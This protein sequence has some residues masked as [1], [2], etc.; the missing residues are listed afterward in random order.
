[1]LDLTNLKSEVVKG[2]LSGIEKEG[3]SFG[4]SNITFPCPEM[5]LLGLLDF[6]EGVPIAYFKSREGL[7]EIIG[8]GSTAKFGE[9][10]KNEVEKIINSNSDLKFF[11]SLRFNPDGEASSEWKAL[12][13]YAFFLP[14]VCWVKQE[15]N[16]YLEVNFPNSLRNMPHERA[17][18]IMAL[19]NHIDLTRS[20]SS[21]REPI[22]FKEHTDVPSK[23]MWNSSINECLEILEST[24]VDKVVL[25][26]KRILN[27]STFNPVNY[28]QKLSEKSENS[29]L[30][31]IKLNDGQAFFS[32]SPERLFKKSNDLL[33]I[34]S[35]AGT[36]TRGFTPQEDQILERELKSSKKDLS[37]HRIVSREIHNLLVD[38]C[39]DIST[40]L[41]EGILKQKYVQHIQTIFNG[42]LNRE[43]GIFEII[44]KIHPTPAVGGFPRGAAKDIIKRLE[45]FDRGLYAG[46]IGII[47]KDM[48]ELAVGIR[49]A[50]LHDNK[51]HI[52]GGAGIILGSTAEKEW[53]ET[54]NKMRNFLE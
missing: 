32:L 42:K 19:E 35:I 24:P 30:F 21:L 31:F 1:M 28:F 22:S 33:T 15:K 10:E 36:R 50:L 45:N 37:E 3:P 27:L 16:F 6:V 18:F 2:V 8:I 44:E 13:D 43:I 17:E 20:L 11:T 25:A 14:M 48:T 52:F 34:D 7:L 26:R 23:D 40:P 29:F 46:P 12:T 39:D 51:L 4:F 47:S 38:I 49:S 9:N 53:D 41:L 54:L 5:N